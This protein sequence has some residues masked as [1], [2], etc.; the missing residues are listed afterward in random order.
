MLR[1][2]PKNELASSYSRLLLLL[3]ILLVWAAP[4]TRAAEINVGP[5]RSLKTLRAGV[6][7]ARPNDRVVLDS[8]VYVDDVVTIDKPLT[9]EG[10]GRGATLRITKPISNR[11]GILVVNAD[12]TIRKITFEGAFVTDADGKNGAGI[13]HQAG[14]LIVDTCVFNDNQNGILANANKDTTITI[15][16]SA[17][18]GNGA[19]DGYSHGIYINAVAHLL[20]SNSTF[21]GTKTGHNIKSRALKT[22]ITDTILDDGVVGTPSYAID[23]PNGGEVVLKGL[24]VTQGQR[25][26]NS[27]MIAY[28]AE[29]SLHENSSLTITGSAF[30][31]RARNS[32]GVNNFTGITA[33][34]SDNTFENVGEITKGLVRMNKVSAPS[35]KEGAIFSGADPNARS[36]FRFHNTGAMPGSVAVRLHDGRDGRYLGTWR[37]PNISPNAAPQFSITT[38]EAAVGVEDIPPTYSVTV[39]AAMTGTFQHVLYR[40]QNG[41]LTNLSTCSAGVTSAGTQIA[42]VHTSNLD[43][44]YRS[45]IFIQNLGATPAAVKIGLY[46]AR[47]G[48]RMGAYTSPEL[49]VDSEFLVTVANLEAM[50]GVVPARDMAHWVLKIENEFSGSLQQVIANNGAA[51]LTDMT[52]VCNLNE[53]AVDPTS[54]V[55]FGAVFPAPPV[56]DSILRFHNTGV[57][58]A[59]AQV[60]IFDV[61]TGARLGQWESQPLA[62]NS[63]RQYAVSAIAPVTN[64]EGPMGYRL[65]VESGFTGFVQHLMW[66]GVG[67]VLTNLSACNGRTTASLRDASNLRA[68][69]T[70]GEEVFLL[71]IY[72]SGAATASPSLD[73]F[74]ARD[75]RALGRVT[76]AALSPAANITLTAVDIEAGLGLPPNS[77]ISAFNVRL[78]DEFDGTMQHLSVSTHSGAVSDMTTACAVGPTLR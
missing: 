73:V 56:V 23:L 67:G 19:G 16:R 20:V 72:N 68:S 45:A 49:P 47:Q 62:P 34:L 63:S 55:G 69:A 21:T 52:T 50:A 35:L 38:L 54:T 31:N 37:S 10:A 8:G 22:T 51:V 77:G 71:V 11:K 28:G 29:K 39:D 1:N 15:R 46:D 59:V 32:T 13:R 26:S 33:T 18:S 7:A 17:F 36:Y 75:G 40:A 12:L 66:N 78:A 6:A 41:V 25:T 60:T 76:T 5:D 4:G 74:D 2:F 3:F 57:A 65:A 42:G 70:E 44:D 64:E 48:D 9:I 61:V 27:T 58:T 24:R 14:R 53:A 30:I 43:N